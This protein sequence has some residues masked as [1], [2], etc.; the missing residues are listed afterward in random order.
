MKS[1]CL[2]S[3][4]SVNTQYEQNGCAVERKPLL[5]RHFFG[6]CIPK[7]YVE[8]AGIEAVEVDGSHSNAF[9]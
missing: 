9:K 2:H 1:K 3:R 8:H 5:M 7:Y 6:S 4:N